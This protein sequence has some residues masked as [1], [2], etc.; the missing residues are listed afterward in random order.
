M[1]EKV[2]NTPAEYA[3]VK[4][5]FKGDKAAKYDARR[6]QGPLGQLKNWRDQQLILRALRQAGN[7]R[8][9]LDI[10]CGTGR[11]MRNLAPRIPY[12]V[13]ADFS[14]DMM[15]ISR[16]RHGD[17]GQPCGLLEYVQCDA[18]RLPY[19]DASFDL[20]VSSRFM[21]H[22]SPDVRV[23]VLREFGRVS[24]GWVLIDSNMQ[25]GLKYHLRG[26]RAILKNRPSDRKR[27]SSEQV[28]RELAEAGLQIERIYPVSWLVSE[29][30]Y[31]LC[32]KAAG[33]R[34]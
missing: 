26:T 32:R 11:T 10:P 29:K 4:E 15:D 13:G 12:L 16:Q 22:L 21:H 34:G 1:Q 2:G 28:E 25:Y 3:A 9:I 17:L 33:A 18:E 6:F 23:R 24:R 20:V 27:I 8:R 31:I 30:W 5:S 14:R 19:V 7:I